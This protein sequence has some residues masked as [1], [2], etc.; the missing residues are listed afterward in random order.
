MQ[1]SDP[2]KPLVSFCVKSYN[3]REYVGV[4]LDGAFSHTYR[5]LEIV[6]CD[7]GSSDGSAELIQAKIDAYKASGGD[8]PIVFHSNPVNLG[9]LGNWIAVGKLAKGE[10]L[11]KADG[12]D[13][14]LPERTETVV[15]TWL[16]LGKKSGVISHCGYV[17][18]M[19]GNI[20]DGA[21]LRHNGACQAYTHDVWDSFPIATKPEEGKRLYDDIVFSARACAVAGEDFDTLTSDKLVKYRHG[22]GD[23]TSMQTYRNWVHTDWKNVADGTRYGL[24]EVENNEATLDPEKVATARK[25]MGRRAREA[26]LNETLI[27]ANAKWAD[28]FKA[29]LALR[30]EYGHASQRDTAYQLVALLPPRLGDKILNW[31]FMKFYQARRYS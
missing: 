20:I 24:R 12:D 26:T 30:R 14:S 10:L 2:Q 13:V 23:T 17:M 11:V 31:Y 1:N 28:R 8:I 6:V 5:P 18:D 15:K 21:T 16:A 3:Q 27:D 7:D 4:S 25:L 19:D 9:N 29:A 22:S